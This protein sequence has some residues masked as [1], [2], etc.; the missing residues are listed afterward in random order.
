MGQEYTR[1]YDSYLAFHLAHQTLLSLRFYLLDLL[2]LLVQCRATLGGFVGYQT[3]ILGACVNCQFGCSFH[4]LLH[5]ELTSLGEQGER[6]ES[7]TGFREGGLRFRPV[8]P[9]SRVVVI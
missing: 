1:K 5:C 9:L 7:R 6:E 2:G 4:H 8:G 3:H